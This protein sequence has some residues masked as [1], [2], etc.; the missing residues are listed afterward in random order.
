MTT[1]K[2]ILIVE[3]EAPMAQALDFKLKQAGYATTTAINGVDAIKAL[4]KETFDL[5]L[6]DLI[7]PNMD[8][9]GV[10][11]NIR[12]HKIAAPVIVLSNLSQQEDVQ[13]ALG[14]GAKDFFI[15]TNI[16]IGDFVDKV[17]KELGA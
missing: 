3:D 8:G 10:L 2:K 13:R 12:K 5:I 9:F 4:K 16:Q 14:Q 17:K 7:L 1:P 15:K 11:D 6:L